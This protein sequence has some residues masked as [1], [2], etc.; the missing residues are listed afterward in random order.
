MTSLIKLPLRAVE[1]ATAPTRFV[2]RTVWHL[3]RDDSQDEDREEPSTEAAAPVAVAAPARP[4]PA[5]RR[6]AAR[7]TPSPK[8]ARRAVRHEP[9]RGQAAALR[10][11]AREAEQE[12][13]GEGAVG[14]TIEVEAPWEGYDAMSTEQILDRLT[15]ADAAVRGV[16]RLYESMHADRRQVILATEDPVGQ[17]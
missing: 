17:P 2:L 16:V 15:G 11:T 8:A 6:A 14:A 5:R 1:L 9:T 7:P 4:R 13:G 12:A 3:L 10:E